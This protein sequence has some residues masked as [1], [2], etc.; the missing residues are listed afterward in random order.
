MQQITDKCRKVNLPPVQ[1][2]TMEF[3]PTKE[4][5]PQFGLVC[6]VDPRNCEISVIP[7]YTIKG[8][9]TE[10]NIITKDEN[11]EKCSRGG[12][13]VSVQLEGVNE[14]AQVRDNND[15]TY[16]ASFIP[17]QVGEVKLSVFVNGEQIK[18]SPYIVM[19][20]DYTS[21]NKPSNIVNNDGNMGRP[22]GI[23]FGK[24]GM[25]AVADYSN[26]CVYIFNGE[27]QLVRKFGSYGSGNGQFDHPAGVAFDND[28]NLYVAD[29]WNHR[30]QKF[31]VNSKC[32]L[33][34]RCEGK[35]WEY[36]IGL[37]VYNHRVYVTG[38][39]FNC[40]SVFQTNGKFIHTIGSGQL[41]NP[42]DVAVNGNNE[43]LVV[44]CHHN[45]IYIFTLDGDYVGKIGTSGTGPGQ[46]N[47]PRGV[48]VDLYG[49]I[50]IADSSNNCVNI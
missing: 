2:A 14:T 35:K 45:C 1:R 28:N 31:N 17:Q 48:T 24:N 3:V 5:F 30:I 10:F 44:D 21:V 39:G 38:E 16:M 6:S 18:G 23:A 29:C 50:L 32:L 7:K 46:L 20:R 8:K 27:D 9:K 11:G 33:Q 40:I 19:V 26:D 4:T 13:Q 25:W 42:C 36:P 47:R 22:W 49:F 15:G 37:L 43:L 41:D 34:F 12:S